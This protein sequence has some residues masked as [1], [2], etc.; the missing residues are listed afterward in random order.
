MYDNNM[1]TSQQVKWAITINPCP[2]KLYNK[3]KW[4]KY[5]NAEQELILCRVI[6]KLTTTHPSIQ[7]LSK[8]FE[9]CPS[10]GQTHLH[11]LFE[12]SVFWHSTLEN[13]VNHSF[14]WKSDVEP[15]RHLDVQPIFNLE[16]WKEYITKDQ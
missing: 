1:I 8:Y 6:S 7:C 11:G 10:N 5:T 16:G 2:N 12:Y 9:K 14:E 13:W 4:G 3:K 15:W